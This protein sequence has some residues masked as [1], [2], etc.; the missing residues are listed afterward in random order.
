MAIAEDVKASLAAERLLHA[1]SIAAMRLERDSLTASL[2][3]LKAELI[4]IKSE[5]LALANT[6]A[7]QEQIAGILARIPD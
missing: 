1:Q 6:G 4:A 7:S 2:Q 5:L 3:S